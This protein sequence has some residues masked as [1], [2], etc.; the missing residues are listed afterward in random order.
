M[1]FQ[2]LDVEEQLALIV[3]RAA[4]EEFAGMMASASA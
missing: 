1:R 2:R 4:R 3:Y